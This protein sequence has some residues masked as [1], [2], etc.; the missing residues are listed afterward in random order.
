M[1]DPT[2]RR[3]SQGGRYITRRQQYGNI[4]RGLGLSG[5]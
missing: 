5:G 3:L 2:T 4:R 1:T